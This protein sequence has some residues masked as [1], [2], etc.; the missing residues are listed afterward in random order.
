[1]TSP[2]PIHGL[3][4]LLIVSAAAN[5]LFYWGVVCPALYRNGARFPTGLMPW[6]YFRD[7]HGYHLILAAEG[8]SSNRYYILL[9]LTWFSLLLG[10]GLA[11]YAL[12]LT[13][14]SEM[15]HH[16]LSP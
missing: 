11:A 13:S 16:A 2:E 14:E 8:K 12:S 4:V 3:I 6:R 5:L 1:M 7:L 10:L 9:F 15:P